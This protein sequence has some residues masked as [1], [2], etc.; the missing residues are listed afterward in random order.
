MDMIR[1]IILFSYVPPFVAFEELI[2]S[3]LPILFTL[4][5]TEVDLLYIDLAT[6][7]MLLLFYFSSFY[8]AHR[9]LFF[10]SSLLL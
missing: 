4:A 6:L 9:I 3:R 5:L 1:T 2:H 10:S 8:I 7:Y